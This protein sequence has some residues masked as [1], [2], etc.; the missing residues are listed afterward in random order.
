MCK[1]LRNLRSAFFS[2]NTILQKYIFLVLKPCIHT[3]FFSI[4]VG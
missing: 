3:G 4:F 1:N 2:V